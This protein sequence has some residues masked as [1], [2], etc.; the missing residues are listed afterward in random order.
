MWVGRSIG[1]SVNW[2]LSLSS[3]SAFDIFIILSYLRPLNMS[4]VWRHSIVSTV[5]SVKTSIQVGYRDN[6]VEYVNIFDHVEPIETFD[7]VSTFT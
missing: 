5:E 1:R 6:H 7:H 4:S 2:S 3:W